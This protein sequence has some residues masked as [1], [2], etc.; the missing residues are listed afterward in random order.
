MEGQAWNPSSPEASSGSSSAHSQS[1]LP[2]PEPTHKS[3]SVAPHAYN[4]RTWEMEAD[5]SR[6]QGHA[7]GGRCTIP[8]LI[9]WFVPQNPDG[10]RRGLT[11]ACRLSSDLHTLDVTHMHPH[12]HNK[13]IKCIF[14]T[15]GSTSPFSFSLLQQSKMP[16]GQK[17]KGR[18]W[19]QPQPS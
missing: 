2:C 16:K 11:P 12:T 19:P 6:I 10:G 9:N 5:G 3:P 1:T 8:S 4:P 17:A 15:Q 14:K 7:C 18:R 13:Q